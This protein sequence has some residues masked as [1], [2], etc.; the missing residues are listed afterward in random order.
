MNELQEIFLVGGGTGGSVVA[1]RLSSQYKVLLLEA[2]GDPHPFHS[3]PLMAN[4]MSNYDQVDWMHKTVRQ[5]HAC[6]GSVGNV[7]TFK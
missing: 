3:I 2:G 5:R 7:K 1:N 4:F 6:F